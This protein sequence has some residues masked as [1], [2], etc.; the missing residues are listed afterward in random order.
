[1]RGSDRACCEQDPVDLVL[2]DSSQIAVLFWRALDMAIGPERQRA[3]LL[4]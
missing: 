2:E 4:D 1:M 3:Q